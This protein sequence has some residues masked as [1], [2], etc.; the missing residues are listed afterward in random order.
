MT[1]EQ[2]VTSIEAAGGALAVSEG[3]IRYTTAYANSPSVGSTPRQQKSRYSSPRKAMP[4]GCGTTSPM[5]CQTCPLGAQGRTYRAHT[6]VGCDGY[7]SIYQS[8]V[9]TNGSGSMQQGLVGR[10]LEPARTR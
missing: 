7:P 2:L 9:S 8:D 5:R 1:A 4:R 10:E 6:V 3:R